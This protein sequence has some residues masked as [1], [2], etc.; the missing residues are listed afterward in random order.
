VPRIVILA[1]A[2]LPAVAGGAPSAEVSLAWGGW[3][4][5]G[6]TTWADVRLLPPGAGP[7]QLRVTSGPETTH[8][9]ASLAAGTPAHLGLPVRARDAASI[10]VRWPGG[11]VTVFPLDVK[12][13][14]RPLVAWAADAASPPASPDGPPDHV[15]TIGPE[16]LA[17]AV[18][19]YDAIDALVTDGATIAS[20]DET[21]LGALLGYVGNCGLAVFIALPAAAR[22]V[23]DQSAGCGGERLRFVSD[24]TAAA[25]ALDDLRAAGSPREPPASAVARVVPSPRDNWRIVVLL[26]AAYAGALGWA[27]LVA[28]RPAGIAMAIA[29]GTAVIATFVAVAGSGALLGVWAES[30]SDGRMAR[31]RAVALVHGSRPGLATVPMPAYLGAPAMCRDDA[32]ADWYWNAQT[33]RLERLRVPVALFASPAVCFSGHFAVL[34]PARL[35]R[36]RGTDLRLTNLG[37]GGWRDGGLAVDGRLFPFPALAARQSIDIARGAGQ[38]P[39]SPAE[40]LA[41]QRVGPGEAG[42]LLA[43]D[44][45]EGASEGW[46]LLRIAAPAEPRT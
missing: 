4:R 30:S 29:A 39:A 35:D 21:R 45:P 9:G 26:L 1:L 6:R 19:A 15:L 18:A 34:R 28:S 24:A 17:P 42:L 43:L 20:L 3:S 38:A 10:E 2:S 13:A 11:E 32:V 46:L 27:G 41:L 33:G 25:R 31:Y 44:M 12:L 37:D 14:E 16:A 5:G 23:L 40:A 36:G 7:V 8:A 22:T